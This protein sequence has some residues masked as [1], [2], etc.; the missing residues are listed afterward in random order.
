M[1]PTLMIEIRQPGKRPKMVTTTLSESFNLT[2]ARELFEAEQMI[3]NNLPGS[4]I[5]IRIILE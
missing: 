2:N 4:D 1:P 3:N 5:K